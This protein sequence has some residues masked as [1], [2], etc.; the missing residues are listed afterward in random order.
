MSA[1]SNHVDQLT[2]NR[3]T[4]E[5]DQALRAEED[6]VELVFKLQQ[7]IENIEAMAT[8]LER[9][10]TTHTMKVQVNDILKLAKNLRKL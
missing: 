7:G 6:A 9:S 3:L 8:R 5:R 2:I 10:A 1:A 4:T